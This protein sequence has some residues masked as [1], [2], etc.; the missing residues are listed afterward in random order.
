MSPRPGRIAEIIP[1][2]LGERTD[3][4]REAPHFYATHT[5]VREALRDRPVPD[6]GALEADIASGTNAARGAL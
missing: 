3:D 4:T 6:T 5:R 2:Y 1:V